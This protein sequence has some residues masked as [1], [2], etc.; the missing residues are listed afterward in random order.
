MRGSGSLRPTKASCALRTVS[1]LRGAAFRSLRDGS[2]PSATKRSRNG[3]LLPIEIEPIDDD[4]IPAPF[5][6]LQTAVLSQWNGDDT[7]P[8]WFQLKDTVAHLIGARPSVIEAADDIG[9]STRQI[10]RTIGKMTNPKRTR[11]PP[12]RQLT[13]KVPRLA[14][15]LKSPWMVTAWKFWSHG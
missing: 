5:N 10:P 2:S 13:R 8:V 14:T 4:S 15:K 3:K 1:S 11:R 7:D 12:W 9:E 6:L